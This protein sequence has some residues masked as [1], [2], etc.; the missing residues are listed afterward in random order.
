MSKEAKHS[1][2]KLAWILFFGIWMAYLESAVVVY[3]KELSYPVR[4]LL[5]FNI[6]FY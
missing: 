2:Y 5:F 1:C 4:W 3:L 6:D